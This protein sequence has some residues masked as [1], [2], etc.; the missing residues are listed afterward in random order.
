[1]PLLFD[2]DEGL[3]DALRGVAL[4]AGLLGRLQ[5]IALRTDT[6]L[7]ADLRHVPLPAEFF[8]RLER[9]ALARRT[10][11]RIAQLAVAASLFIAVGISYLGSLA[12]FLIYAYQPNPTAQTAGLDTFVHS[13][14][15]ELLASGDV[16]I[17]PVLDDL[18]SE[19]IAGFV[20]DPPSGP[21]IE[22]ALANNVE[23]RTS[24][25]GLLED[26][27]LTGQ[28]KTKALW[29]LDSRHFQ[30]GLFSPLKLND[31]NLPELHL[32]AGLVPKGIDPPQAPGHDLVFQQMSGFHPV[33]VPELHAQLRTS[34][35]PLGATPASYD[36]LRRLLAGNQLPP[37]EAVRTEE[38]LAAPHYG[39]TLP[40]Q[41]LGLSVAGGPSPLGGTALRILQLGVQAGMAG[42]QAHAPTQLTIAVDVSRSMQWGGRLEMVRSALRSLVSQLQPGDRVSLIAFSDQAELLL[43]DAGPEQAA[44]LLS[45]IDLLQPR[46]WTNVGAGLQLAYSLAREAPATA[47]QP[48]R[49]VLVCDSLA[50]IDAEDAARIESALTSAGNRVGL[51]VIDLGSEQLPDAPLQAFARAA[52]GLLS[53]AGSVPQIRYALLEALTGQSQAV[54]NEVALRVTF[55]PK[56]VAG[57][58]LLGHE[59][60]LLTV[61]PEVDLHAG[62]AAVGMY[63]LRLKPQGGDWVGTALLSWRN[64]RSGQRQ[65]LSQRITR[66]NFAA[67]FSGED[68]SLQLATLFAETAEWLR[69]SPFREGVTLAQLR[70]LADQVTSQVRENPGY[71]ELIALLSA[72]QKAKVVRTGT[73]GGWSGAGRN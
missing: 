53:R 67:D 50:G 13:A 1:M 15:V 60:T 3:D 55:N 52:K 58:R 39:F 36:L 38:F 35:V 16:S 32:F 28:S 37:R 71:S 4:P 44:Y 40:R 31:D 2:S 68:E 6:E 63:E 30:W 69:R 43:E 41:P 34:Q 59:A 49:V 17:L 54:A 45:A 19:A 25:P 7:D 70:E 72:A 24:S 56:V 61:R 47:T 10:A 46:A 11:P 64:P 66:G 22:L 42:P 5:Q 33:V 20:G 27:W 29:L 8:P 51:H 73:P 48:R 21:E 23:P 18:S 12:S 57:Y 26:E 14:E 65:T 9:I 62:Q